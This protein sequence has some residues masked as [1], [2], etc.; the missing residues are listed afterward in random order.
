MKGNKKSPK[1]SEED[2]KQLIK[3][4]TNQGAADG[5]EFKRQQKINELSRKEQSNMK[6][7]FIPGKQQLRQKELPSKKVLRDRSEPDG[8]ILN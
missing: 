2:K 8:P 3:S 4:P 6:S 5:K 1:K 7:Q